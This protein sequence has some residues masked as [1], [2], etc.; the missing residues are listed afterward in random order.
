[1]A[2]LICRSAVKQLALDMAKQHKPFHPFTRV[3]A[4]FYPKVEAAVRR[5]VI[6]IVKQQP[7]TGQTIK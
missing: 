5:A 7:S 6:E 4:E 2:S 1:M 3:S